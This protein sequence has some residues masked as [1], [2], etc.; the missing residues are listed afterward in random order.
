MLNKPWLKKALYA[1]FAVTTLVLLIVSF[2]IAGESGSE[3]IALALAP[4]FILAFV[5]LMGGLTISRKENI[6]AGKKKSIA[7]YVWLALG[8]FGLGYVL[9]SVIFLYVF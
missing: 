1:T 2:S 3:F 8:V 5:A 7:H 4:V 6:A 9:L